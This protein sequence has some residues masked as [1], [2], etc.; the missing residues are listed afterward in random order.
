[1][2]LLNVALIERTKG[3]FY[4]YEQG[5]TPAVGRLIKAVDEE[6]IKIGKHLN[7]TVIPDPVL[8][9]EQGY[10]AEPT[11]DVGYSEAPV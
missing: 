8:G 3:D 11:Y 7:I 2:S 6:R 10:Q 5:V 1:M 4:F 9:M